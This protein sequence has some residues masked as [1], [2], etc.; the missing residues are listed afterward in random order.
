MGLS[1]PCPK[2]RLAVAQLPP[3]RRCA[4]ARNAVIMVLRN[5]LLLDVMMPGIDGFTLLQ[6]IRKLPGVSDISAIFLTA[7]AETLSNE[8][9]HQPGV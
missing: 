9:K 7:Q 8:N 4:I 3:N 5:L 1:V 2:S 6:K